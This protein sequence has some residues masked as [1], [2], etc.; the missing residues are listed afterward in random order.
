MRLR[1]LASGYAAHG[2]DP[3]I[4]GLSEDSRLVE[5][6][7]LFIAVPG[8]HLD[9]H[10]FIPDAIRRGAAAVLVERPDALVGHGLGSPVPQVVAPSSRQALAACA[11][12]FYGDPA[13]ELRLIGS[14]G[15]FGKTSTSEILRV[16]LAADGRRV[17]VLGSLG[18]RYGSLVVPGSG[19]TTPAPVELHRA[20]R[21][22]RDAGA[23]TVIVEATT[24]GMVLGRLDG[25]T[26]QDGLVAAIQPGEHT[27]YHRTFEDY[28]AAKRRFA[29]LVAPDGL[30]VYD[31]DNAVASELAASLKVAR[32]AGASLAGS[33]D[34]SVT[35]LHE[36]A[37]DAGGA[38]FTVRGL[39]MRSALLGWNHAR[40]VAL[41]LSFALA[42]GVEATSMISVLSG[43]RP[44]PRRMERL[45][46]G[47]RTVLDDTAAH[48]DSLAATFAVVSLL[49]RRDLVVAYAVRGSRGRD[50]N[51]RNAL[52]L[53]DLA[54][55]ARAP[56]VVV[57]ASADV[58]GPA[59]T[60]SAEEIDEVRR[61]LSERGCACEWHDTLGAA[62]AAVA[63]TSRPGDLI[64]LVGA[65]GMN[66]G[67][68]MLG[69]A[70]T[71]GDRG[72]GGSGD[73]G[74]GGSGYRDRVIGAWES[75]HRADSRRMSLV[76]A[77]SGI[78][79]LEGSG[80]FCPGCGDEFPSPRLLGG[81]AVC[82]QSRHD[83]PGTSRSDDDVC[84][85][86]VP[87][88]PAARGWRCSQTRGSAI[89]ARGRGRC[90]QLPRR[91]PSA[92]PRRVRRPDQRGARGSGRNGV[93]AGVPGR[94]R[95]RRRG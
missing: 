11:R 84:G 43:L 56:A 42:D 9:G 44:L 55:A 52:A 5:P 20:L 59:D 74:I 80:R 33:T 49:P 26:F 66:D 90:G 29:D 67:A 39:R 4:T 10:E 68:R 73:R 65:Q 60:A 14:T 12:R 86:R 35:S 8:T 91:R 17:G 32:R 58:T 75:G 72:I 50:V 41:A 30:L 82:Y 46:I 51:R 31:A 34:P 48:P 63:A 36:I 38:I 22:L 83:T 27:D 76:I 89:D 47:G 87:V 88:R 53:A 25:V 78:G 85:P 1:A 6:G 18:A 37:L 92:V 45:D 61:G 81:H 16:L 21:T 71:S 13:R 2:G 70:L 40:N 94:S 79:S 77:E 54:I 19:L 93:L 57:T 24:H 7:F 28:V 15:T 3:E 64:V 69:Q 62:T 23:D 95:S